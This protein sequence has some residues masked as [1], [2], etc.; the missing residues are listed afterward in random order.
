MKKIS[1][2]IREYDEWNK[3]RYAEREDKDNICPIGLTD[4]EFREWI[5]R[6]LLGDDWVF[7]TPIGNDQ[8]NEVAM[9]EFI[10]RNAGLTQRI[11]K[12]IEKNERNTK[13]RKRNKRNKNKN[14]LGH[15]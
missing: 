9:E 5:K 4:K 12:E 13:S 2:E 3:R 15:P 11:G 14:T 7:T 10:V 1:E 6:I 8:I